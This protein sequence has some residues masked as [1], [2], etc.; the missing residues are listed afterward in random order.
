MSVKQ[1]EKINNKI[2][3]GL[4]ESENRKL[5]EKIN[6]TK[7]RFFKKIHKIAKNKQTNSIQAAQEENKIHILPYWN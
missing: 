4:N 3:I 7:S 5:T 2:R 1:A 6:K